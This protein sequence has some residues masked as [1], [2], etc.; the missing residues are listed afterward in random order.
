MR[1]VARGGL[2]F[3]CFSEEIEKEHSDAGSRKLRRRNFFSTKAD[4]FSDGAWAGCPN[5]SEG[6]TQGAR[7]GVGCRLAAEP[8]YQTS[9]N[10]VVWS[11][12][13]AMAVLINSSIEAGIGLSSGLLVGSVGNETG[14]VLGFEGFGKLSFDVLII[15]FRLQQRERLPAA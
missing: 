14:G 10:G 8:H 9:G 15:S 12:N 11:S 3:A 2:R 6:D 4:R 13:L 5:Y 7:R 1:R